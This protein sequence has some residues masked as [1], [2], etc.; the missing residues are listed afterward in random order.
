MYINTDIFQKK[1]KQ[2]YWKKFVSQFW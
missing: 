2:I 1:N